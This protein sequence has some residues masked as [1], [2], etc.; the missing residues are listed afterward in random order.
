MVERPGSRWTKLGLNSALWLAGCDT[1]SKPLNSP[2]LSFLICQMMAKGHL[3][4]AAAVTADETV[5]VAQRRSAWCAGRAREASALKVIHL[6][7]G[8]VHAVLRA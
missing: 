5:G 2:R 7:V 3:P 6:L 4:R 1:C 8:A